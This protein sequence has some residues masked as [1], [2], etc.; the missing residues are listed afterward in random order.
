MFST[1]EKS[2][3]STGISTAVDTHSFV[4]HL[5]I[6][7]HPSSLTLKASSVQRINR[8]RCPPGATW[9]RLSRSTQQ[10]STPG[11]LR[12]A[13][14]IP[15]SSSYTT[16][17]PFLCTYRRFRIFPLPARTFLLA[18]TFSTS[19]YAPNCLRTFTALA[20]FC[21]SCTLLSTTRGTSDTFSTL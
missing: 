1:G 2:K 17:G 13:F 5:F 11:R 20:V 4:L 7:K 18:F 9:R 10:I 15:L 14:T 12:N 21:S 19:T 8:P 16:N 6:L 3:S